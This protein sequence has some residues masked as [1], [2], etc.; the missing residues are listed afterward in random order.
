MTATVRLLGSTDVSRKDCQCGRRM[1]GSNRPR[2]LRIDRPPKQLPRQATCIGR[3]HTSATQ[4]QQS[5]H[6]SSLPPRRPSP[7]RSPLKIHPTLEVD[8]RPTFASAAAPQK[9]SLSSNRPSRADATAA[10]SPGSSVDPSAAMAS[11]R[12]T[13]MPDRRGTASPASRRTSLTRSY[14]SCTWSTDTATFCV[15]SRGCNR[16]RFARPK[17]PHPTCTD[18][19]RHLKGQ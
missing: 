2:P 6:A 18:A 15:C 9:N 4:Q 11:C 5:Q 3:H 8:S 19:M 10:I 13:D 7:S 16:L 1:I 14:S 17:A 12:S